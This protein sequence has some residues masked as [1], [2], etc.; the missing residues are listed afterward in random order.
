MMAN[1]GGSIS[2]P[3][4]STRGGGGISILSNF[5]GCS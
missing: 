1:H 3:N 2:Q 4:A 5:I